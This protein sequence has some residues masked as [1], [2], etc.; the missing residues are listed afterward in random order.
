MTA[1][2]GFTLIELL[3]VVLIIGILAS[4]AIPRYQDH[5]ARS[6]ALEAFQLTAGLRTDLG[7]LAMEKGIAAA[8]KDTAM[9]E[10]A[11]ALEGKYITTGGVTL[12]E[13]GA[14][15]VA[16]ASG[17]NQGKTIE[18][19]PK[20]QDGQITRWVCKSGTQNGI[21]DKI[22]PSTCK[23]DAKAETTTTQ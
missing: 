16:F 14:I 3:I 18:L 13:S 21:A 2:K 19:V 12:N 6:Q 7:L 11:K 20:L 17:S 5:V 10:Q 22:L 9:T 4:F 1:Q 8:Q 15:V 23:D